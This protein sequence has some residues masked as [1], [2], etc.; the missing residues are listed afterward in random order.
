M[1]ASMKPAAIPLGPLSKLKKGFWVGSGEPGFGGPPPIAE[2][3]A[4]SCARRALASLRVAFVDEPSRKS[5]AN[6]RRSVV[7]PAGRFVAVLL[8]MNVSCPS[9]VS[10]PL[11][12]VRSLLGFVFVVE[13]VGA[14]VE[15]PDPAVEVLNSS[16]L[17]GRTGCLLPVSAGPPG[18]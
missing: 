18:G 7:A 15:L 11:D 17:L 14:G 5:P 1:L 16:P 2:T 13:L 4:V 10:E 3:F 12:L 8:T 9:H 6:R